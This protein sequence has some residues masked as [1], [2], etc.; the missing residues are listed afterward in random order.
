MYPPK[1]VSLTFRALAD[2]GR[3]IQE[4]KNFERLP[5]ALRE[6]FMY[7]ADHPVIEAL[8]PRPWK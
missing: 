2:D 6:H 5:A 8:E 3:I 1:T 4:I 7:H